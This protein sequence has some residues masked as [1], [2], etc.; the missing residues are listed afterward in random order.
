VL[1]GKAIPSCAYARAIRA[2]HPFTANETK[3]RT[4]EKCK[5]KMNG[6][7]EA[8]QAGHTILLSTG[9]EAA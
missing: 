3:P 1:L 9:V 8:N 2:A 6:R 5:G 7:L 4:K